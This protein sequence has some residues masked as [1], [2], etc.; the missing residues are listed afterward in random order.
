[1]AAPDMF[2]AMILTNAKREEARRLT[3]SVAGDKPCIEMELDDGGTRMLSAPPVE[4][5]I[6]IIQTLEQGKKVF[7]SNVFSVRIETVSVRRGPADV[8]ACVS[9]WTIEHR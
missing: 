8:V 3:L 5:L 6:G 4:V 7:E 1:M 2:L 9:K